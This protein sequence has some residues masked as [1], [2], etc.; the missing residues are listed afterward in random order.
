MKKAIFIGFNALG[1]TLCTTPVLRAFRKIHPGT[2]LVYIVQNAPFCRVLD[3]NPDIDMILY[4]EQMYLSGLT[5]FSEA[6]LHSL[7]LEIE[8]TAYLYHF[9]INQVCSQSENFHEHI[10]LGFSK[11]LG[12]PIDSIRPVVEIT[13][14]ES[15]LARTFIRK[16][17][18]IFSMHSVSNP[19]RTDEKGFVKDWPR[20]RWL[21]LAEHLHSW[22]DIDII[23]VG[24]ERDSQIRSPYI[25]NLYGPI[26]LTAAWLQHTLCVVTLENGI[27]HLS[28]AVDAPMVEIYSNI[29]P[30]AFAYPA[31]SSC[32]E[33]LY[34][35]PLLISCE[36]VIEAV[37]TVLTKQ[38]V[39]R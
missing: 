34:N 29:V 7:P 13:L 35:D 18:I 20:E 33:V 4:S 1:D 36:E 17:Y 23:A 5:F 3:A 10:S 38:G 32:C 9:D 22:G 39:T 14:E 11:L 25:R 12:I 30:L 2:F 19:K 15:R 31:E 27:A 16:P 8:E 6:W 28:A 37:K 24:S 26:K 21:Q